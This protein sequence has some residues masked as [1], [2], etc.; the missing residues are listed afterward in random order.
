MPRIYFHRARLTLW[1]KNQ[2]T[3]ADERARAARIA[4]NTDAVAYARGRA[5]VLAELTTFLDAPVPGDGTLHVNDPR[6]WRR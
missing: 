1:I 2:Q 3:D 5:D 4:E 6:R